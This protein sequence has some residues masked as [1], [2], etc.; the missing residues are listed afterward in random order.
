MWFIFSYYF[1]MIREEALAPWILYN[2]ACPMS[3]LNFAQGNRSEED[4]SEGLRDQVKVLVR[5][6]L[7]KDTPM[8][9]S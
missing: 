6:S 2:P 9:A 5:I 7:S 4:K 8:F 1:E 3:G